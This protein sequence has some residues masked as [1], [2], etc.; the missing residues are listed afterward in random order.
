MKLHTNVSGIENFSPSV[1]VNQSIRIAKFVWKPTKPLW[2]FPPFK[3]KQTKTPQATPSPFIRGQENEGRAHKRVLWLLGRTKSTEKE[4]NTWLDPVEVS[5]PDLQGN[6]SN[7]EY[8][9][10]DVY[11]LELTRKLNFI[12]LKNFEI[13]EY[14]LPHLKVKSHKLQ[15]SGSSKI[16]QDFIPGYLGVSK[17]K[18]APCSLGVY[19]PWKPQLHGSLQ[20]DCRTAG[21]LEDLGSGQLGS[22]LAQIA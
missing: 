14:S 4:P 10:F 3:I 15:P 6:F 1:P 2:V 12:S 13:W 18:P 19:K 9:L 7:K 17:M 8:R 11:P 20:V 22:R 5:S 21:S 16:P